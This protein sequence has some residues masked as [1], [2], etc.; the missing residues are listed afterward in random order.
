MQIKDTAVSNNMLAFWKSIFSNFDLQ[1]FIHQKLWFKNSEQA[2]V[3][4]KAIFFGDTETALKILQ[5]TSPRE[6]QK[7]GR[8]V[9]N[10]D[11][12]KWQSVRYQIMVEVLMDKFSQNKG[13]KAQLLSTGDMTLIEGSPIDKIWGIGIHWE[14]RDC[15]DKSK[16][17]GT[18]LLGE[19]LMEVRKALRDAS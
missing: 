9:K 8:E 10:Y 11:D 18:N 5:S 16:W 12:A 14:D 6:C 7:L 13:I 2:F 15:F 3:W 17:K 4:R 19:A 1:N